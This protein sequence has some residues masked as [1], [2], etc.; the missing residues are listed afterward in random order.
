MRIMIMMMI[1]MGEFYNLSIH[2]DKPKINK[3]VLWT[4]FFML[5]ILTFFILFGIFMFV[6][7]LFP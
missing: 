1:K 3:G 6:V 5:L 4:P 7:S 2:K